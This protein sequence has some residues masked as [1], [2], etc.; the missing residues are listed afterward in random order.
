M[1]LRAYLSLSGYGEMKRNS[2]LLRHVP[3]AERV[4]RYWKMCLLAHSTSIR[5]Q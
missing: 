5:R 2:S 1:L 4:S 3:V